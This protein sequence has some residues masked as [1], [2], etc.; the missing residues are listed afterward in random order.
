[1]FDK[2]VAAFLPTLNFVPD[3]FVKREIL[4]KRHNG[5]SSNDMNLGHLK[6]DVGTLFSDDIGYD[7]IELNNISLY[8]D[9]FDEDHPAA[10]LFV[11]IMA[12]CNRLKRHRA[13][14]K[15]I[16]EALMPVAWHST[17]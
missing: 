12:C 4:G 9:N 17:S 10:V 16:S 2:A 15:V 11:R 3:W 5:V 1:M 13:C 14:K 6:S 7:A 8:D